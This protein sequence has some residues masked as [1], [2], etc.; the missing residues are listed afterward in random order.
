MCDGRITRKVDLG[1]LRSNSRYAAE[2]R[3]IEYSF[4]FR[5]PGVED[6]L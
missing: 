4:I 3:V 5:L 2:P 1:D 6:T